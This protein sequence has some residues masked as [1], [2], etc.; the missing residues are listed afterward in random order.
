M[1]LAGVTEGSSPVLRPAA[2][3]QQ[4]LYDPAESSPVWARPRPAPTPVS[5]S[6]PTPLHNAAVADSSPTIDPKPAKR[7]RRPKA[8]APSGPSRTTSKRNKKTDHD[9]NHG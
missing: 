9:P 4:V 8:G 2:I 3:F 5:A 1:P 7:T 6:S